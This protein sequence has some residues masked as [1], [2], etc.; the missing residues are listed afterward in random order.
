[1][2]KVAIDGAIDRG[3]GLHS[4]GSNLEKTIYEA[5][6]PGGVGLMIECITDK[7]ARSVGV[8]KDILRKNGASFAPSAFMFDRKGIINI[9]QM[10]ME[11]A[12]DF[13]IS[14]GVEDVSEEDG[15]VQVSTSRRQ[16]M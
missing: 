10:T 8:V 2:T 14:A 11:E 12:L 9:E 16:L 1:M 13:G 7:K 6:G 15:Q 3:L 4:T 5:I